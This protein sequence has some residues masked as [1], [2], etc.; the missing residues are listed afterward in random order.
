MDIRLEP[1][2]RRLRL[3]A[4]RMTGP[5]ADPVIDIGAKMQEAAAGFVLDVELDR[6]KRCVIDG[7]AAFLHRRD[8][9]VLVALALEYGSEQPDQCG[10]SDR[11]LLVEPGA[12]RRDPH[13]DVAAVG[14][15]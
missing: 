8:Q 6:E 5:A 1:S 2:G 9:K 13:V 11:G 7:D 12:V 4:Q 3:E 15:V 10:P 14:R